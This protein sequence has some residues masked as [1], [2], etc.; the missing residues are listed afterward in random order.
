L[1]SHSG[2]TVPQG[3][4][5]CGT[6]RPALELGTHLR[7]ADVQLISCSLSVLFQELSVLVRGPHPVSSQVC[8]HRQVP[9]SLLIGVDCNVLKFPARFSF[10]YQ[11]FSL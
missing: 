9:V 6:V 4:L 1:K 2:R 8:Q 10:L 11:D 7:M 5:P 3:A